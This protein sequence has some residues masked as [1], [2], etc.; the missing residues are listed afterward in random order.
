MEL[1]QELI[2]ILKPGA[3]ALLLSVDEA[4]FPHSVFTWVVCADQPRLQFVVDIGSGTEKNLQRTGSAA[5]QVI[6]PGNL[7]YLIKGRARCVNARMSVPILRLAHYELEVASAKDQSWPESTVA[8]LEFQWTGT[9]SQRL[10]EAETAVLNELRG[11]AG[12]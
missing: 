12:A 9:R 7:I 10:Q 5:L 1:P 6:A 3:P 8:P 4:G 2:G 11:A